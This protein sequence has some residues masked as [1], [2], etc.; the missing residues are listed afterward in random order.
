[1]NL[2]PPIPRLER[3]RRDRTR[4]RA[5]PIGRPSTGRRSRAGP[6]RVRRERHQAD[7]VILVVVVALTA[8]GILMVYSSSALKGYLS[9]DA[10]TFATVGPQIQWAILGLVAMVADDAGRL[11]L[12]AARLG[13]VLR[14]RDRPARARLRARSSTSWSA[15][16]RAGSS[17]GRCRPSIRPSSPSSPWSSTSPT[18]SPS[19]ARGIRGFWAGTVPFLVIVAPVIVLV[20]KEP[21]LGTTMVITLTAFTMFFVAGAN[22]IHLA[23]MAAGGG[24]RR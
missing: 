19:A 11:P 17:S 16:R 21:D 2:A 24:D 5:A 20:F 9:Q 3:P 6:E 4:R 15:A 1:M 18:G 10:D 23:V 13:A 8:I 12:P 14:R 7:Y 22:L